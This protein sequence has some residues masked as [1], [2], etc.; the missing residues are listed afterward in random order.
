MQIIAS[1]DPD[2]SGRKVLFKMIEQFNDAETGLTEPA[3]KLALLVRDPATGEV[4]GGLRAISYYGWM[5][6]EL[7]I[8]PKD[9]R[10]AGLGTRLIRT[11]EAE[12]RKLGLKGVWLDTFSFQARPFYERLGY[13]LF[14]QI[15]DYP[16]GGARY[17]LGKR[18]DGGAAVAENAP[19]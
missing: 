15:D 18:L 4:R 6:I 11:A 1:D 13:R 12:A 7:L 5:F 16:P 3:R 10:G 17:F 14:G 2:D 9:L 8:L 19:S